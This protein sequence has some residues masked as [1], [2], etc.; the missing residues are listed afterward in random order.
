MLKKILRFLAN[1][2][3][4]TKGDKVKSDLN[5][6]LDEDSARTD[7]QFVKARNEIEKVAIN[8]VDENLVNE[9]IDKLDGK[10]KK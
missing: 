6:K 9:V 5:R 3:F 8:S 2:F 7:S 4:T 1:L 10:L